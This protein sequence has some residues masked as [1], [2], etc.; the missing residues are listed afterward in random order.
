MVQTASGLA[1]HDIPET[2]T[3]EL[4]D[5]F[6]SKGLGP[7]VAERIAKEVMADPEF[8]LETHAREE[9]GVSP[10][11]LGNPWK[12]ALSSFFAF[13]VGAFI[14][15]LPWLVGSGAAA[16]AWSI[17]LSAVAA[18]ALGAFLGQL[19][20]RSKVRSALRALGI[21]VLAAGVTWSIGRLVGAG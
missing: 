17:A 1:P 19:T 7:D 12:A 9:F 10:S 21:T 18:L 3:Q 13:V 5:A 14:P 20:G 15:L 6:R 11:S 4:I 8:A 16:V 2:E